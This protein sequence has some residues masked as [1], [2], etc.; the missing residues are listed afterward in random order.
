MKLSDRT[1]NLIEFAYIS[2]LLSWALGFQ[3]F[4]LKLALAGRLLYYRAADGLHFT[5]FVVFYN[6]WR[7]AHTAEKTSL[8]DPNVQIK[9][10]SQML[11]P[12][13]KEQ[14]PYIQGTP[15]F[16]L[17]GAP[18]ARLDLYAAFIAWNTVSIGFFLF[19]YLRCLSIFSSIPGKQKLLFV[20]AACA[21]FPF[22]SCER[23]GQTG[24]LLTGF[25]ASFCFL[26]LKGKDILAGIALSMLVM[27]PQYLPFFLIVPLAFRKWKM[28]T[29]FFLAVLF[30]IATTLS[31]LGPKILLNYPKAL[32]DAEANSIGTLGIFTSWMVSLRGMLVYFFSEKTAFY[33]SIFLALSVIG[34]LL[35]AA[36]NIRSAKNVNLNA[37]FFSLLIMSAVVFS[38]HTFTYDLHLVAL[39]AA[40]GWCSSSSQ[41]NNKIRHLYKAC[42]IAY[43]IIGMVFFMIMDKVQIGALSTPFH[44]IP[45]LFLL[46]YTAS[47]FRSAMSTHRQEAK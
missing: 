9:F 15:F 10:F 21:S 47:L 41:G 22:L 44:L 5:D 14:L 38:P 31:V 7:I 45:N 26:W 17:F 6:W 36:N 35:L 43:P 23:D 46:Y 29:G 20:A 16:F 2:T 28:L 42:L 11:G 25:V 12:L 3:G 37:L 30:H 19:A 34:M 18:F 32:F 39:S 40:L 13:Q 27:K 24:A 8:Y 33:I 1:Q 4:L